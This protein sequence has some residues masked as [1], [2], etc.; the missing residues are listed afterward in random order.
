M[1]SK[2][3]AYDFVTPAVT[4]TT[5]ER[6][7][8]DD[9]VCADGVKSA[10]RNT[11]NG[12]PIEP[13]DTGDVAYRVIVPAEAL[14]KDPDL[15]SLLGN[16]LAIRLGLEAHAVSYALQEGKIYNITI[17][18]THNTEVGAPIGD[19]EWRSQADNNGLVKRFAD[20]VR[21]SGN[22]AG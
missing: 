5:G 4:L 11:I 17:D 1:N 20:C 8:A 10:I 22:Y 2:V 16:G 6:L 7:T 12:S 19:E 3:Q 14:Q 21:Q 15:Q 9:I 13:K 18:I